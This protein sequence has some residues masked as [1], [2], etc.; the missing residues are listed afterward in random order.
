MMK[1]K[2]K[3]LLVVLDKMN[4]NY[5]L[6]NKENTEKEIKRCEENQ[7]EIF[8]LNEKNKKIKIEPILQI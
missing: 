8:Q 7:R 6:R 5:E 1:T 4:S 3:E 2:I